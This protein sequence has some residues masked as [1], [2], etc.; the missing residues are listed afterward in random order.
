M[1]VFKDPAKTIDGVTSLFFNNTYDPKF[2]R[3]KAREYYSSVYHTCLEAQRDGCALGRITGSLKDFH[4]DTDL[5]RTCGFPHKTYSFLMENNLLHN[6][7]KPATLITDPKDYRLFSWRPEYTNTLDYWHDAGRTDAEKKYSDRIAD[8]IYTIFDTFSMP[9]NFRYSLYFFIGDNLYAQLRLVPCKQYTYLCILPG[10]EA[11][12]IEDDWFKQ[13]V[14]DNV[15]WTILLQKPSGFYYHIG[16]SKDFIDPNHGIDLSK[17]TDANDTKY[18]RANSI[19]VNAFY[20]F[21]TTTDS[22]KPVNLLDMVYT[23]KV[24]DEETGKAYFSL[25]PVYA[26]QQLQTNELLQVWIAAI[27]DIYMTAELGLNRVWQLPMDDGDQKTTPTPPENIRYFTINRSTGVR[28]PLDEAIVRLYFPNVYQIEEGSVPEN[29]DIQ[30]DVFSVPTKHHFKNPIENYMNY[31]DSLS[32]FGLATFAERAVNDELDPIVQQYIPAVI[33][34]SIQDYLDNADWNPGT[35]IEDQADQYSI[36]K[37]TETIRDDP[38]RALDLLEDVQVQLGEHD[39]SEFDIMLH[40]HP[41]IYNREVMDNFTQA[42]G[43]IDATLYKFGE[44]HI[45]FSINT[46]APDGYPFDLF[47]DGQLYA[48]PT[49]YVRSFQMFVYIP[50]SFVTEDSILHVTLMRQTDDTKFITKVPVQF[51]M[52]NETQEFPFLF[53]HFAG[54]DLIFYNAEDFTRYPSTYFNFHCYFNLTSAHIMTFLIDDRGVRSEDMPILTTEDNGDHLFL[55][56]GPGTSA[57]SSYATFYKTINKRVARNVLS[58]VDHPELLENTV[59]DNYGQ[60][61]NPMHRME[62]VEPMIW[63][64]LEAPKDFGFMYP[65]RCMMSTT[66]G[67]DDEQ[68]LNFYAFEDIDGEGIKKLYVYF[69]AVL[70]DT[71]DEAS[72]SFDILM[73]P[74][75]EILRDNI[76]YANTAEVRISCT[77]EQAVG[78]PIIIKSVDEYQSYMWKYDGKAGHDYYDITNFRLDAVSNRFRV[79]SLDNRYRGRLLQDDEYEL[80]FGEKVGDTATVRI[81]KPREG[82]VQYFIEYLPFRIEQVGSRIDNTREGLYGATPK[83]LIDVA[84]QLFNRPMS[85]KIFDIYVNGYRMDPNMVSF[86]SQTKF[87]FK[88]GFG[89]DNREGFI[90]L[91][92]KSH[93]ADVYGASRGLPRTLEDQLMD[94]DGGFLEYMTTLKDQLYAD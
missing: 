37:I 90:Y 50:K 6:F 15:R 92:A 33:K 72:V 5:N 44:P 89:A 39:H 41:A 25:E 45:W 56:T 67:L 24:V 66:E 79:W 13:A 42:D 68:I 40:D 2:V 27:P 8:H 75:E 74:P 43:D 14:A 84:D 35:M 10:S 53:N 46:R 81:L 7:A 23:T 32:E 20:A 12:G 3:E 9:N 29:A 21:M 34:Y 16:E 49:I 65:T 93:D 86:T 38:N 83:Y 18:A 28:S 54:R 61:T 1:A 80:T 82:A 47:I 22:T 55:I 76:D 19:P 77:N 52:L 88:D 63:F 59:E 69:P 48:A 85:F 11:A 4:I 31:I 17:F 78:K 26:Q 70:A 94:T 64:E 62:F 73:A 71:A 58:F 87:H 51:D 57:A 60:I 36:G 30:I 91:F